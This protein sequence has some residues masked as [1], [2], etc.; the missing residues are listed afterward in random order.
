MEQFCENW[1]NMRCIQDRLRQTGADATDNFLPEA[2]YFFAVL[3]RAPRKSS[4]R[5]I[6]CAAAFAAQR[7]STR[8]MRKT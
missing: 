3:R 8:S 7:K 6:G 1:F 5:P 4:V 2:F